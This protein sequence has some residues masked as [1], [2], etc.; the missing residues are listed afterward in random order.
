MIE[1]GTVIFFS[2][3]EFQGENRPRLLTS[4]NFLIRFQ[5]FMNLF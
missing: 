5:Q 1:N 4:K 2:F 3:G